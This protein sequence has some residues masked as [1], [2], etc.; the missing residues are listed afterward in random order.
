MKIRLDYVSNSSSS[1]FM[2]VGV[3]CEKEDLKEVFKK[4]SFYEQ[5]KRDHKEDVQDFDEDEEDIETD[6]KYQEEDE[7]DWEKEDREW[8]EVDEAF[9]DKIDDWLEE[10]SLSYHVGLDTYGEDS[11]CV[12]M[13][14]EDM[15]DDETK[16]QFEKRVSESLEKLFG[17]PQEIECMIDGGMIS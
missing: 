7:E 8:E 14:Y 1:S 2:I 5:Y 13:K 3:A 16:A 4:S 11:I 6:S 12:G 17:E 10:Y 15:E 9:W